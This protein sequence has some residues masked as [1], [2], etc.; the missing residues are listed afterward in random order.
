MNH[1][2]SLNRMKELIPILEDAAKAYYDENRE[3]MPNFE[4]DRLYD[5]LSTLEKETGVTLAGSPTTRVGYSVSTELIKESH[6]SPLLSLDKTKSTAE[7]ASWLS[8]QKG[9]LSWKLDGLTVALTYN[10]GELV[11]AVTRG[12]GT[13]GE[14]ITSNARTFQN[15]PLRIAH[16]GTLLLRGEAVIRYS[17][18]EKINDEIEDADAKYKNPRN[19]ASGSV[20]QLNSE[21]TARRHVR[22]YAFSLAS[23]DGI[24]FHN[25]RAAQM[26]FLETQGFQTA[27]YFIVSGDTVED[28]VHR[29]A[30][31]AVKSDLP[32]DGL[33]L[34]YD[35]IAYGESLGRTAKFPRDAIAFKWADEVSETILREIEWSASRTGLINPIAIF[36][37]VEIEGS[38]V[39]R[40]SV[41]NVSIVEELRLG[42]GDRITVYKANMIIPQI[43][44]NLTMSGPDKIPDTCPVCGSETE[45]RDNTGVRTLYCPNPDCAAKRIKSLSHF[46][47]RNAL[48]IEGLS[49]SSLEKLVSSGFIREAADLFGL[50]RYKDRIVQLEGFGERSYENLIAAV[51]KARTVT[52]A[53]LLYSL[54]VPTIGVANAKIIAKSFRYDW[55]RIEHATEIELVMIDGIGDIMAESFVNW[56]ADLKNKTR[57]DAILAQITWDPTESGNRDGAA[58]PLNGLTFVITGT[59]E[60]YPNRD[61]LKER[62]EDLGGKVT[63]SVSEKTSYLINNDATSGSSKNKKAKDLGVK[64][65]TEAE[66]NQ[67]L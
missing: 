65:I 18:F 59:L 38:T 33:V 62:I 1:E 42:I 40:A 30:E 53:R 44:E 12:D 66:F 25:S 35:D 57:L 6:P 8:D 48:N 54:G 20:R 29:F 4:Y 61:A 63:G 28:E 45:I 47:S 24:D 49:E 2:K 60:A 9:L 41:H 19:L 15:I 37:P 58:E 23:A 52:K 39:S 5:E 55:E 64:I 31:R 14:V 36:D 11:K 46:V 26:D 13:V 32:S 51:N 10:D 43:A 50:E 67:M 3:L 22:F 34:T 27:E 7:L 17:D 56:F 16:K 21:I